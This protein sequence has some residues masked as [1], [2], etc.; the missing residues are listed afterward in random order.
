MSTRRRLT[1]SESKERFW[2]TLV[3]GFDPQQTS[4]R[5]WC[6]QQGVSQASFYAWRRKLHRGEPHYR[7]MIA[8]VLASTV[9]HSD[10]TPVK[11]RDAQRKRQY[12]G[13]SWNYVGDELHPLT[14]FAYMPDR[15]RDGPAKFLQGYRGY[16]QADAYAGY[17]QLYTQSPGTIVEV[18]CWAH[19]RRKFFESRQSDPLRAETALACIR[20]LYGI[21]RDLRERVANEWRDQSWPERWPLLASER[22]QRARPVLEQFA[23]WRDEQTPRLLPKST[24]PNFPASFAPCCTTA[25]ERTEPVAHRTLTSLFEGFSTRDY[26]RRSPFEPAGLFLAGPVT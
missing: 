4:I 12:T 9:L 17:D 24:Q 2:R 3:D 5:Q 26:Q 1:D 7:L 16:S 19:A 6:E 13:R 22:Q 14:V 15:S 11:V 21:E 23:A 18:A 8:E 25:G 20:Q 10:D